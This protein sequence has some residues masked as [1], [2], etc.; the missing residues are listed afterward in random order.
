MIEAYRWLQA[1]LQD[2]RLKNIKLQLEHVHSHTEDTSAFSELNRRADT[3][4]A[5]AHSAPT[6]WTLSPLTARMSQHVRWTQEQGFNFSSWKRHLEERLVELQFRQLPRRERDVFAHPERNNC[7]PRVPDYFYT[8]VAKVQYLTRL[9]LFPSAQF[10][11][12]RS[13]V[14]E[15]TC[16]YCGEA[17]QDDRHPFGACPAFEAKRQEGIDGALRLERKSQRRPVGE[18]DMDDGDDGDDGDETSVA[19]FRRYLTDMFDPAN[20]C[21]WWQGHILPTDGYSVSAS[22]QGRAHMCGTMVASWI[23]SAHFRNRASTRSRRNREDD[24]DNEENDARKRRKLDHHSD[25]SPYSSELERSAEIA[26]DF[27]SPPQ[28]G[29]VSTANGERDSAI[30]FVK[31][32]VDDGLPP[33][34]GSIS[35]VHDGLPPQ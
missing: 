8:T 20:D 25:L 3:A 16:G 7:A 32:S 4:A 33:E 23:G 22:Q 30:G 12:T 34:V 5:L 28:V 9:R 24:G 11:K 35:T 29:S 18:E 1:K 19:E 26:A 17:L 14:D 13:L 27:V 10:L 31:T 21:R 15:A 2:V 6:V